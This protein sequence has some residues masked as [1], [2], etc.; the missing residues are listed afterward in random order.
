MSDERLQ[1][2]TGRGGNVVVDA[3]AR[4]G[5]KRDLL[6]KNGNSV[7][8]D[9]GWDDVLAGL[10]SFAK[11]I[12]YLHRKEENRAEVSA[13]R[14]I[15]DDVNIYIQE[16][17]IPALVSYLDRIGNGS[18]P[19]LEF[20]HT[21]ETLSQERG[22]LLLALKERVVAHITAM[23]D[24]EYQEFF[25]KMSTGWHLD[26]ILSDSP[27]TPFE[28]SLIR[29][30]T[31][32]E[33]DEKGVKDS[34]IDLRS[35][36]ALGKSFFAKEHEE[37]LEAMDAYSTSSENGSKPNLKVYQKVE[38]AVRRLLIKFQSVTK[39]PN[40]HTLTGEQL[41]HFEDL[42][43]RAFDTAHGIVLIETLRS[44]KT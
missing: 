16:R 44:A 10:E 1:G 29:R 14:E 23:S 37:L 40:N 18:L 13:R 30:Y 24:E 5:A 27:S 43:T 21:T 15:M 42:L 4:F 38:H 33:R 35:I 41:T 17:K 11:G 28:E 20:S 2:E 3:V 8:I 36:E 25:I 6:D 39:N 12:N 34:V 19:N 22:R 26:F 32:G 31:V 7:L 9:L